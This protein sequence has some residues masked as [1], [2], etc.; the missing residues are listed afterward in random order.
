MKRRN[1]PDELKLHSDP[2]PSAGEGGEKPADEGA[3][4]EGG[5]GA[6]ASAGGEGE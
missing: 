3:G 5:E 6:E 1:T 2:G 4:G